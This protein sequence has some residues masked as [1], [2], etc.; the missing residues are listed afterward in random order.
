[1]GIQ[2]GKPSG[3]SDIHED[4]VN[5]RNDWSNWVPMADEM[6]KASCGVPQDGKTCDNGETQASARKEKMWPAAMA[7]ASGFEWYFGYRT[8]AGDLNLEDYR[9]RDRW[10]DFNR[11]CKEFMQGLPRQRMDPDDSL[12]SSSKGH[13]LADP[14]S[15]Y[16]VYLP[17]GGSN[18]IDLQSGTYSLRWY[19][20]KSGDYSGSKTLSGGSGTD[21]GSPP[22]GGDA[23]ALIESQ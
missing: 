10:W 19:D 1:V 13:C 16:A 9:T 6:G 20:P 23:V 4:V 22:F 7:N 2:T 21:T 5:L 8:G 3:D 15:V 14:G 12:I 11:Y 18:S 17:R